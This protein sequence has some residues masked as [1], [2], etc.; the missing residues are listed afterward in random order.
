MSLKPG[1]PVLIR[2][3]FPDCHAGNTLCHF[4]PEAVTAPND[5]YPTVA[6]VATAGFTVV[7]LDPITQISAPSPWEAA[8]GLRREAYT[9]L[10]LISDDAYARGA[11]RFR[12]AARGATDRLSMSSTC[13]YSV[14]LSV[15]DQDVVVC[16]GSSETLAS[17]NRP[18]AGGVDLSR[19]CLRVQ[20]ALEAHADVDCYEQCGQLVG[21]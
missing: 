5:N 21:G 4:W 2:S 9:L 19:H 15:A 17:Q 20:Q 8:T 14:D 18:D 6:T 3:V 13:W 12:A 16:P 10:Q 7:G 1:A 11:E